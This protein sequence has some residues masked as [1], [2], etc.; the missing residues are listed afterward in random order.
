[1][2]PWHETSLRVRYQETDKMGIVYHT[3]YLVW[4]EVGRTDLLRHHGMAYSQIEQMGYL[5]PVT[6]LECHYVEPAK[7][8]EEIIVKTKVEF[9]N[10][11]RIVFA[12][13]AVRKADGALLAHGKTYHAWVDVKMRPVNMKKKLPELYAKLGVE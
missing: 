10:G 13:E 1:M 9:F 11:V 12:Y 6:D 8:E 5:L 7:Y 2:Q 4:F 3:N